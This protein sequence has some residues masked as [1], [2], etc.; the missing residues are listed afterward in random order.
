MS[1]PQWSPVD[2]DTADLLT[3]L[4]DDG[5]Q[6]VDREWI[7]FQNALV[8]AA[9]GHGGLIHPNVLRPMVRNHVAPCR[10]G[11]FVNRALKSRLIIKTG[12]WQISDDT[13]GRNSGRPMRVYRWVGEQ[14]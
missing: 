4:A 7:V 10:I 12:D 14:R 9:E 11:A 6:C 13:E 1:A 8:I 5:R 2:D 3:V